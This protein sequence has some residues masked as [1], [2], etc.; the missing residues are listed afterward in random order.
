VRKVHSGG[1][2]SSRKI[3]GSVTSEAGKGL[4]AQLGAAECVSVGER[5]RRRMGQRAEK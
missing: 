1:E 3:Y 2:L 4:A 5:G